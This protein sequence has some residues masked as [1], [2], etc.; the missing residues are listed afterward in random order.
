M[1]LKIQLC[2]LR[3]QRRSLYLR[4]K[5]PWF[6]LTSASCTSVAGGMNSKGESQTRDIDKASGTIRSSRLTQNITPSH[7]GSVYQYPNSNHWCEFAPDNA[8]WRLAQFVRLDLPSTS[9]PT[10]SRTRG[11][12]PLRPQINN[13][14]TMKRNYRQDKISVDLPSI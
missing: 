9:N 1:Q 11:N 10:K 12:S 3:R 2:R 4:A 7:I 6:E 5:K 13:T 14:W 8:K